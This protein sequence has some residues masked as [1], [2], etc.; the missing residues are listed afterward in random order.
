MMQHTIPTVFQ[1]SKDLCII[2]I[3]STRTLKS[4]Y[5]EPTLLRTDVK[6][7]LRE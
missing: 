1:L 7:Q 2:D 3:T 4:D 5:S 6:H